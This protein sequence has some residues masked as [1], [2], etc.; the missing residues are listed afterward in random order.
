M[1]RLCAVALLAIMTGCAAAPSLPDRPLNRDFQP[2][3]F[4][5]KGGAKAV[6][7]AR[8]YPHDG[9]VML[10]GAWGMVDAVPR[11]EAAIERA[12]LSGGIYIRDTLIRR[13]LM[14][15]REL[16]KNAPDAP[17]Q[18]SCVDTG[19]AWQEGFGEKR[20]RLD[21]KRWTT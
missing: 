14:F 19:V 10:C 11:T 8:T 20:M 15:M 13:N 16:N 6:V 2:L 1:R 21:L 9:K 3:A 12:L 18:A 5:I 4:G 7:F 17:A